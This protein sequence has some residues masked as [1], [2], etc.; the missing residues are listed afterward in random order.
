MNGSKHLEM[1]LELNAQAFKKGLT[2]A[3]GAL[4]T[5][6]KGASAEFEKLQKP[7]KKLGE[8]EIFQGVHDSFAKTNKDF[9][10]AK[11]KMRELRREMQK[12]G[13]EVLVES[14]KDAKDSV[15]RLSVSLRN[16]KSKLDTNRIT[17]KH[18]SSAVNNLA[19]QQTELKSKL[20]RTGK[21]LGKNNT[22]LKK[23]T[24]T[25]KRYNSEIRK[26]STFLD[27]LKGKIAALAGAYLGIT[28]LAGL[29]SIM[30]NADSAAF[31]LKASLSAA[32]REFS[33]TGSAEKWAAT[34]DQLS[35]KLRIY[36]KQELK[37]AAAKTIDMTK[38]LGLSADQ[39]AVVIERT[40]DLSA[41]KFQ[42]SDGV[43]RVTAALRGEAEASEALGL[44]LNENYVKSWYEA[45]GATMGA[46]KNLTDL[47]KAQVRYNVFLEQALPLTGKA[48]DSVTTLAGAYDLVKAKINDAVSQ[49]KTA[50]TVAKEL[51]EFVA[52]NAEQIGELAAMLTTAVSATLQFVIVHKKLI[53]TIIGLIGGAK[54]LASGIT[55]LTTIWRAFN[56]VLLVTKSQALST[57]FSSLAIKVTSLK[58][59]MSAAVAVG[60]S[61]LVWVNGLTGVLAR[62]IPILGAFTAGFAI[63]KLLNKFAIVRKFGVI[64]AETLTKG[65]LR[66]KQAWTWLTGGDTAAVKREIEDATKIYAQMFDDIGTKAEQATDAVKKQREEM[67]AAPK[68][69][70]LPETPLPAT[71]PETNTAP[72]GGTAAKKSSASDKDN[73]FG[74]D[75]QA[76]LDKLDALK[77]K[78]AALN[79][80]IVKQDG[81]WTNVPGKALDDLKNSIMGALP[82][83]PSLASSQVK[84]TSS[85]AA[86]ATAAS[87]LQVSKVVEIRI[88]SGSL[89]V[90]ESAS[91]QV[92]NELQQ[93]GELA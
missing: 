49:N 20:D 72:D 47:E 21:T 9:V 60:R 35:G 80:R 16:Q 88:K 58:R 13:G 11:A 79:D 64:M 40:G 56:A 51:A 27:T 69:V 89:F 4:D 2:S 78:G 38:R 90:E 15:K 3:G 42:L 46:W 52:A 54:L 10:E 37:T 45:N 28:T 62:A 55:T 48:A 93:L 8:V 18:T 36:S 22:A 7:L 23:S 66:V 14:Y 53:V 39:M 59:G 44:T 65:F 85:S 12:P 30:K 82:S 25:T 31:S 70:G 32:N 92:I 73:V 87:Q 50:I 34:I 77:K 24:T 17:I 33:N 29:A 74:A 57:W 5:M 61:M 76:E 41:G 63:G 83:L 81:V 1:F 43:E 67:A 91:E 84:Q 6:S 75:L 26:S 68:N 71:T 19:K 86:P